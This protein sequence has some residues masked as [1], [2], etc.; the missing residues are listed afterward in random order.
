MVTRLAMLALVMALLLAPAVVGAQSADE[1]K[2][3]LTHKGFA[4][5][6]I[7]HENFY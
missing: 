4:P 7:H 3:I 1:M 2:A 5:G 6:H